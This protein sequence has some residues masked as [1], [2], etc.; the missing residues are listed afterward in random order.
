MF[1]TIHSVDLLSGLTHFSLLL[2]LTHCR[3]KLIDSVPSGI[4][5]LCPSHDLRV[6]EESS[7]DIIF[8]LDP[9]VKVNFS[10]VSF[11]CETLK[12]S[13]VGIMDRAIL[14][15]HNFF[16]SLIKGHLVEDIFPMLAASHLILVPLL[17]ELGHVVHLG[18]HVVLTDSDSALYLLNSIFL[19]NLI[20][21]SNVFFCDDI[22][23]VDP[24]SSIL[25]CE[26]VNYIDSIL[27]LLC[28]VSL[29]S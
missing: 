14:F 26:S 21:G 28:M 19:L 27:D 17:I 15:M 1:E 23:S 7:Q 4:I 25:L 3:N 12:K 9:D 20:L 18:S 6:A 2:G 11:L 10:L 5:R 13:Q 16:A 8:V 22:P 24:R 29:G